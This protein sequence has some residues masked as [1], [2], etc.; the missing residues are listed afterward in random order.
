VSRVLPKGG[1]AADAPIEEAATR[2]PHRPAAHSASAPTA[3]SVQ[4]IPTFASVAHHATSDEAA[5][6][7]EWHDAVPQWQA[8]AAITSHLKGASASITGA[9]IRFGRAGSGPDFDTDQSRSVYLVPLIA[10]ASLIWHGAVSEASEGSC[11]CAV[12]EALGLVTPLH[13]SQLLAGHRC[14][15]PARRSSLWLALLYHLETFE[16]S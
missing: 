3:R 5:Y 12:E 6:E 14:G 7:G 13:T 2:N 11:S 1:P 10:F 9:C 16:R 15:I 8:A 4:S